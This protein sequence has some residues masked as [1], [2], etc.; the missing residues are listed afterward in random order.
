MVDSYIY[1]KIPA[2]TGIRNNTFYCYFQ[3]QARTVEN[4]IMTYRSFNKYFAYFQCF[5]F[6]NCFCARNICKGKCICVCFQM[7]HNY[8]H[9]GSKITPALSNNFSSQPCITSTTIIKHCKHSFF[10]FLSLCL[11]ISLYLPFLVLLCTSKQGCH[12]TN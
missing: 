8:L 10:C 1:N 12:Q 3:V 4:V 5:F 11:Y 7:T 2:I 6:S 9:C